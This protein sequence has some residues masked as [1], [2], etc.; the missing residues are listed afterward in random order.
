VGWA[1]FCPPLNRDIDR[2]QLWDE[3]AGLLSWWDLPLCIRGDFNVIRFPSQR[4]GGRHISAAIMEFSDFIFERGLMDLPLAGGLRTWSNT[5][6][7]SRIDRFLVSPGWEVR[8]PEA[9]QKRLICLC[10]DHFPI[11]LACGGNKG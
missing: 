7:W 5:Q 8:H 6:S 11:V 4:F 2:C 1:G 9:L 10:S 3:L